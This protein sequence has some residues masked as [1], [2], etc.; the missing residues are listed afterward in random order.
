M[1]LGLADRSVLIT[2]ATKGIGWASA[3]AF[4]AE[5]CRLQLVARDHGA[6]QERSGTLQ[7][8]HGAEVGIHVMD[9]RDPVQRAALVD[10]IRDVDV[11]VNNAGDIPMGAL[12]AID[13]SA[14]RAAWELKLHGTIDL[15]RGVLPSMRAR[16]DGVVVNVIGMSALNPSYDYVCGA[17]ANAALLAFTRAV[18]S[19][20]KA[21]GVRVVGVLP[22]ATRTERLETAM[23]QLARAR[24]GDERQTERL[25]HDKVWPAPIE[26][27]QVAD[28]I[29]YLAS[30]RARH[31][32]GVV[33]SLGS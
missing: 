21:Y 22:P 19:G 5:G 9:L 18:G 7:R 26:P 1:D 16:G 31:L 13:D 14:W 15:T 25:L 4:A 28:S 30:E 33:L 3:R 23:K 29:V 17:T 24:Y 27:S 12:E 20:S 10:R 8:E 32:S 6:L 11:L 2:G